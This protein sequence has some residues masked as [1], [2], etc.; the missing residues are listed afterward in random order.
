MVDAVR[1]ERWDHTA[2]LLCQGANIYRDPKSRPLP[3]H[4][5][6]PYRESP[7]QSRGMSVSDLHALKSLFV[8]TVAIT[9]PS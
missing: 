1:C 3:F 5:F 4:K 9:P 6:H 8:P 7:T 2:S